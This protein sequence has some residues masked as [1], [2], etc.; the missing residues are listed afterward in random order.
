M[1]SENSIFK[2]GIF[3]NKKLNIVT[4]ISL[5]LIAIVAFV[6]GIMTAFGMIYLPYYA[7][8]IAIGLSLV[9]I[10]VMELSKLF[11]LIKVHKDDI[12]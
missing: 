3:S 2:I 7:V 6:P 5:C 1:R 11:G 4:L 10:I 8:F 9:P 12:K